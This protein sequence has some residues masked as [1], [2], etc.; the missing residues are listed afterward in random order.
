[1][2]LEELDNRQIM[3]GKEREGEEIKDE[4]MKDKK[5]RETNLRTT[6]L[7]LKCTSTIP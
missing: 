7:L 2:K 6:R 3:I 1:V 4:R 5:E